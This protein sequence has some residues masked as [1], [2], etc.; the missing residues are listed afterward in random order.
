MI[1]DPNNPVSKAYSEFCEPSWYGFD[2]QFY[3]AVIPDTLYKQKGILFGTKSNGRYPSD[4]EKACFYSQF[5]LW[6]QSA[7]ENKP[8]LILEHDALLKKPHYIHFN[9]NLAVQYF[10]QHAMEAVMY[11]PKFCNALV[12]EAGR[13]PMK[14]GP[15]GFVD[16]MLCYT[17]TKQSRYG[18]PHARYQGR[19]APVKSVIDPNIGNTIKHDTDIKERLKVDHDLFVEIDL[20]SLGLYKA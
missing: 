4:T 13:K 19:S 5:N 17:R 8:V 16:H 14:T 1:R 20:V 3:D 15:M 9:P 12:T 7:L 10:G 18:M 11:H 2:L 6:K